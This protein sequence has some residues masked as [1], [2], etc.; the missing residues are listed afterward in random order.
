MDRVGRQTP[1]GYDV[2]SENTGKYSRG[3]IWANSMIQHLTCLNALTNK[4]EA[5]SKQTAKHL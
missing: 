3:Y 5:P 2:K 4:I 1:P